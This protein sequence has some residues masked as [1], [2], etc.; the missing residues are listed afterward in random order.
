MVVTTADASLA[1]LGEFPGFS[2]AAWIL[3][4][5]APLSDPGACQPRLQPVSSLA[6]TA[7]W[8]RKNVYPW[9]AGASDVNETLASHPLGPLSRRAHL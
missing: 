5:G 4:M 6:Q 7:G 9:G 1:A 8:V 3:Q 2:L